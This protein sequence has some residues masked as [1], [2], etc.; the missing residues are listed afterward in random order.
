MC[1]FHLMKN[2]REHL[3]QV[4]EKE[5]EKI[6]GEITGLHHSMNEAEF[7]SKWNAFKLKWTKSG[8]SEFV[9]YFAKEW[10]DGLHT[11]W[12][13]FDSPV[14]YAAT[15]SPIESFNNIIKKCWT[16]RRRFGVVIFL[17]EVLIPML[18]DYSTDNKPFEKQFPKRRE[19]INGVDLY[20]EK[21]I[22]RRGLNLWE[23]PIHPASKNVVVIN[24]QKRS[25]DCD[26]WLK[27][28]NCCHLIAYDMLIAAPKNQLAVK[29]KRGA[30]SKK[31]NGG[32][33]KKAAK[34]LTFQK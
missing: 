11:A 27:W 23:V 2:V 9:K 18:K 22:I 19:I 13:I 28:G 30:K 6:M 7:A 14:G 8:L 31:K 12:R 4:P 26:L 17:N 15:N 33:P 16:R 10:I 1:W 34:A 24:A 32:R 20:K 25:C 29:E 21:Q 3:K 5:K